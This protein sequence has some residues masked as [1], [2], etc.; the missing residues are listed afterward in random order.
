MAFS[1]PIIR[2]KATKEYQQ[3]PPDYNAR[4][5]KFDRSQVFILQLSQIMVVIMKRL[6]P[7]NSWR[8]L[9]YNLKFSP[10]ALREIRFIINHQKAYCYDKTE[11]FYFQKCSYS[12][13][14]HCKSMTYTSRISLA[15]ICQGQFHNFSQ[16]SNLSFCGF[17]MNEFTL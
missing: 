13:S 1:V 2:Q 5:S 7:I 4:N 9:N 12:T 15:H 10:S 6:T 3:W 11:F 8:L 14:V 17:R 16:V